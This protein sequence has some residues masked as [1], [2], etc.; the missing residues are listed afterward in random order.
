MH[1]YWI[2]Y[3]TKTGGI[4]GNHGYQRE[5]PLSHPDQVREIEQQITRKN[6]QDVMI[7]NIITLAPEDPS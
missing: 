5:T 3:M 1:R 7:T 6:G 4:I 2:V